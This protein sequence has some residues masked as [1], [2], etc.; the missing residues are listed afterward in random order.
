MTK[1]YT[2]QYIPWTSL[3][4]DHIHTSPDPDIYDY[5]VIAEGDSWFTLGGMP[6]AG[7]LLFQLRFKR[8]AAI[9]NYA[10]PG[11]TI[12][13]M[14][15]L[16]ANAE[17]EQALLPD[18]R[19]T[20]SL[21][22]L[23]G[24]G[25]DLIDSAA[26][27][28]QPNALADVAGLAIAED[29]IDGDRLDELIDGVIQGYRTLAGLR[30]DPTLPIVTHTYDYATPRN[31]PA[32]FFAMA[33]I[34][35]WLYPALTAAQVPERLWAAVGRHF[36]DKLGD[37]LIALQDSGDIDH[38]HVVETRGVLTPAR[39]QDLTSTTHWLN[40]IH[41]NSEGYKKLAK[42]VMKVVDGLI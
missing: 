23:S 5:R 1:K 13:T 20:W 2:A 31:S 16:A 6:Q 8:P 40:E 34:G 33:L 15:Q 11:Q 26:D 39:T 3:D 7:N 22:L 29:Y 28:I 42:V 37:A 32:L 4:W 18:P 30:T 35:P 38:F 9:V 19:F 21:M 25:N 27:I 14:A 24:G 10:Y 17:F 36:I 41:P 12:V